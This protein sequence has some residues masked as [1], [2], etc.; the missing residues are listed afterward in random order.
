MFDIG[1]WMAPPQVLWFRQMLLR[2]FGRY[3]Q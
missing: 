2:P 1:S 3:L